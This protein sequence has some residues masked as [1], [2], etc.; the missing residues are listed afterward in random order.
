MTYLSLYHE[1]S[2]EWC[3]ALSSLLCLGE[4][5]PKAYHGILHPV[6][7][8]AVVA[9]AGAALHGKLMGWSY[10]KAQQVYLAKVCIHCQGRNARHVGQLLYRWH[11][12]ASVRPFVFKQH[13][14]I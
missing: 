6:V 10:I 2:H 7:V 3:T 12:L 1:C 14:V 4:A 13:S 11:E 5:V 8:T 9:N